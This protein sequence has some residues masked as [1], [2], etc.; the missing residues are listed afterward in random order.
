VAEFYLWHESV[1][2]PCPIGLCLGLKLS[3]PRA[4][5][6][7]PANDLSAGNPVG[8]LRDSRLQSLLR[9]DVLQS[10]PVGLCGVL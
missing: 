3:Q 7:E 10:L 1:C 4:M 2:R 9:K 6:W 5:P 8:A